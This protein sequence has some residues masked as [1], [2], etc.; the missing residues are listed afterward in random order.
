LMSLM[1]PINPTEVEAILAQARADAEAAKNA[2]AAL[3]QEIAQRREEEQRRLASG[4]TL[5]VHERHQVWAKAQKAQKYTGRYGQA[6]DSQF[7]KDPDAI[8]LL[9]DCVVPTIVSPAWLAERLQSLGMVG[10][11]ADLANQRPGGF[12]VV[13]CTW[14]QDP[15]KD[16][17]LSWLKK[18]IPL[19]QYLNLNT[20]ANSAGQ[21]PST[22]L[23]HCVPSSDHFQK[24]VEAMGINSGDTVVFYDQI[25]MHTSPRAWW[26]FRLFGHTNVVVLDGGLPEYELDQVEN[27]W[28][29][30]V[31]EDKKPEDDQKAIFNAIVSV[32][33]LRSEEDI[34]HNLQTGASHLLDCRVE[35]YFAGR[36]SEEEETLRLGRIAGATQLDTMQLTSGTGQQGMM[37]PLEELREL[38]V[39]AGI[40][41]S[42]RD[43][44]LLLYDADGINACLATLALEMV[45]VQGRRIAMYGNTWR[46]WGA[47]DR[48]ELPVEVSPVVPAI[49][50]KKE[51]G[52][53]EGEEK[54]EE[55]DA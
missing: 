50:A 23:P 42:S 26:L 33:M 29:E 9:P 22:Q 41:L 30:L 15:A 3:E 8:P 11:E 34:L 44:S 12:H 24:V 47:R 52:E 19:S 20:F 45:G 14:F 5:I 10:A 53:E 51:E 39:A 46:E 43:R 13:D 49:E 17:R 38:F 55:E 7:W 21:T 4:Q 32:D 1:K 31:E 27:G 28:P 54:G 37:K 18:R 16:G 6:A 40:D 36:A 2:T 48:E 25:G 35:H